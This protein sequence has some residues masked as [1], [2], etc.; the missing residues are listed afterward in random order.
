M[1]SVWHVHVSMFLDPYNWFMFQ[2][3]VPIHHVQLV[4]VSGAHTHTPC[5]TG[6]CFRC[7]YPYTMYN[8]FMFQE[9]GPISPVQ[10]GCV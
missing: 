4:Y 1:L 3:H 5:T 10:L 8:W 6:L 9:H 7:T 2:V